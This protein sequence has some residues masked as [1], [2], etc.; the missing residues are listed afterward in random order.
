[1]LLQLKVASVVA[2]VNLTRDRDQQQRKY[3]PGNN[4]QSAE[5]EW[6]VPRN[7]YLV[8]AFVLR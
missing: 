8:A 3:S 2:I 5:M 4:Q 1:M 7:I 6:G